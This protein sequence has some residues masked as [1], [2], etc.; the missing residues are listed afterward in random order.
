MCLTLVTHQTECDTRRPVIIDID[1]RHAYYHPLEDPAPCHHQKEASGTSNCPVHGSCCVLKQWNVCNFVGSEPGCAGPTIFHRV[2]S[3]EHQAELAFEECL[4]L[5]E[6]SWP[7]RDRKDR[8]SILRRQFFDAAAQVAMCSLTANLM[9]EQAPEHMTYQKLYYEIDSIGGNGMPIS[10]IS[11]S[12]KI[13]VANICTTPSRWTDKYKGGIISERR[14]RHIH[15]RDEEL[16]PEE[17]RSDFQEVV[18]G[19]TG[20]SSLRIQSPPMSP[21]QLVPARYPTPESSQSSDQVLTSAQD[22][23]KTMIIDDSP[24]RG[25][26]TPPKRK[27]DSEDWSEETTEPPKR[28][29]TLSRSGFHPSTTSYIPSYWGLSRN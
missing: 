13:S 14:G 5:S 18:W 10:T 2:I 1:S 26:P 4:F 28:Q 29:R 16:V 22:E 11:C 7:F 25:S 23:L 6:N 3:S 19:E 24:T 21:R 20:G 12:D 8:Y 17:D 27:R 15:L 9:G